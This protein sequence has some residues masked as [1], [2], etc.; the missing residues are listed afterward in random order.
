MLDGLAAVSDLL[1]KHFPARPGY[2][3]N[4]LPDAPVTI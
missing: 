2:N 1:Q 3:P 4:E